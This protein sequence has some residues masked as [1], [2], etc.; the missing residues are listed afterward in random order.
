MLNGVPRMQKLI[1][2]S[3]NFCMLIRH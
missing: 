1:P 3:L 2:A